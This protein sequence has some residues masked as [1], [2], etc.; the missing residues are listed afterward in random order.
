MM[1][2]IPPCARARLASYLCARGAAARSA[3][4]E[5]RRLPVS[6]PST[7]PMNN[8]PVALA[9]AIVLLT[10]PGAVLA[11]VAE[12]QATEYAVYSPSCNRSCW[13]RVGRAA[14]AASADRLA[15]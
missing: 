3:R 5:L 11:Q 14:R 6:W 12:R 4:L 7:K 2:P 9:A 1:Q 8:R 10:A 15:G 13:P